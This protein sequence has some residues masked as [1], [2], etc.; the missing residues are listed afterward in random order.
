MNFGA[1][2][3][4]LLVGNFGDGAIHA[5]DPT[6]GTLLGAFQDLDGNT[7][8]IPGLWGLAA[9]ADRDDNTVYYAAGPD[10]EAHGVFGKLTA[11]EFF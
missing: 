5:Y 3:G 10:N 4:S 1:F 9:G 2:A 8:I 11:D 7:M 6:D